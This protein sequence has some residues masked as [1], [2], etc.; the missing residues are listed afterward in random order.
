[1]L[2]QTPYRVSTKYEKLAN[3]AFQIVRKA[4]IEELK[5]ANEYSELGIEV[6]KIRV[7]RYYYLINYLIYVRQIIDNWFETSGNTCLNSEDYLKLRDRYLVDCIIK[8]GVCDKYTNN[9]VNFILKVPLCNDP[10]EYRWTG[11]GVCTN[12]GGIPFFER[13]NLAVYQS[14]TFVEVKEIPTDLTLNEFEFFLPQGAT[15]ELLD[16]RFIETTEEFCCISTIPLTPNIEITDVK[17]TEMTLSW[18]GS[19]QFII[20]FTDLISENVLVDQ[21][22]T[23]DTNRTFTDLEIAGQYELKVEVN[24]CAGSSVATRIINTPPFNVQVIF[25]TALNERVIIPEVFGMLNADFTYVYNF[26]IT[27]Y[28]SNLDIRFEPAPVKTPPYYQIDSVDLNG[29]DYINN[30]IFDTVISSVNI[31]GFIEVPGITEDKTLNICGGI[32]DTCAGT[33]VIYDEPN[34]TLILS[35]S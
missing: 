23:T 31:G 12:Q 8:E 15:Q 34:E 4:I 3:D 19:D 20:T 33:Q 21:E 2:L 28:G 26:T 10:F 6:T 29:V 25:C 14:G 1:M 17:N 9:L 30:V 32:G 24:N 11:V 27:E 18:S 35:L 13:V 16:A 5:E 7:E 22:L